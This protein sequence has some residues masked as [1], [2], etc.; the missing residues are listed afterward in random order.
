MSLRFLLLSGLALLALH[1]PVQATALYQLQ[2]TATLSLDGA[3]D[4]AG[5]PVP[6]P[7]ELVVTGDA[8]VWVNISTTSGNA[9]AQSASSAG[10]NAAA[11]PLLGVGDSLS[12]Q[13]SFTGQAALPL[14]L[15]ATEVRTNGQITLENQSLTTSYTAL[16]TLNYAATGQVTVATPGLEAATLSQTLLLQV[17]TFAGLA[18]LLDLRASLDGTDSNQISRQLAFTVTLAPGES[19]QIDLF[20]DGAGQARAIATPPTLLLLLLGWP[21]LR[22][23]PRR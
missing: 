15:A 16:F 21:A 10:S 20:N 17:D 3:R 7:T 5:N 12:Q 11:F 4:A 6:L 19:A 13:V 1:D 8:Y 18:T 14:G 22:L 9:A 23:R 2:A